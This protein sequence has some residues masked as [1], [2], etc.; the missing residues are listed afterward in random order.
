MDDD[1]HPPQPSTVGDLDRRL[2][3]LLAA[4]RSAA[5]AGE[6]LGLTLGATAVRLQALRRRLGV[7]STAKVIIAVFGTDPR[8]TSG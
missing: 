1:A 8:S 6:L 7:T 4:G 5:E 2:V 3:E